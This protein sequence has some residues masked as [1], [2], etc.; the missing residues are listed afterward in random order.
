MPQ[1]WPKIWQAP[2]ICHTI[3]DIIS[4]LCYNATE[5][6][7]RLGKARVPHLI[8]DRLFGSRIHPA[9]IYVVDLR[10]VQI[11]QGLD[12]VWVHRTLISLYFSL[13][14]ALHLEEVPVTLLW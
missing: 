4:L 2:Q 7:T 10:N 6:G 11:I 1:P 3:S 14:A 9:R 12:R 5:K 8:Q 13:S